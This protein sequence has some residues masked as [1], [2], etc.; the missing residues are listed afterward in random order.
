MTDSSYTSLLLLIDATTTGK[1]ARDALAKRLTEVLR[2]QSAG[3]GRLSVS[4]VTF[5]STPQTLAD[6]ADPGELTITIEPASARATRDSLALAV[7]QYGDFLAALDPS[8]RPGQVLVVVVASGVDAASTEYSAAHVKE[9]VTDQ[10]WAYRWDF[11][12]LGSKHDAVAEAAQLGIWEGHA[13]QFG[14]TAA[15]GRA[16]AS[17]FDRYLSTKRAGL[18]ASFTAGDRKS[19]LAG[20]ATRPRAAPAVAPVTDAAEQAVERLAE[21]V[22][23]PVKKAARSVKAA[24]KK[25][26][27]S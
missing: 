9:I 2:A 22:R 3:E 20:P 19:A 21:S 14:S 25:V 27:P 12:Y 23:E 24:A 5:G 17:A 10:Q 26:L 4:A 1:A 11:V 6:F 8:E 18:D 7:N 15:E 13:L 16:L